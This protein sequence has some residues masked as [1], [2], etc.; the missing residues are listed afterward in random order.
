VTTPS[1][2]SPS[3]LA[4]VWTA[5]VT[6]LKT[7]LTADADR[8]V[9]HMDWLAENGSHG[10]VLFGTTGEANS[11]S[12]SERR[13][14][15]DE[16]AARGADFDRLIV[17]TGNTAY[18]DAAELTQHALQLGARAVL[19]LPPFYYAP[20]SDDGLFAFTSRMLE[21]VS[22]ERKPI[23]LYHYPRM[24]GTGYSIPVIHR[25]ME[26]WPGVIEGIK[27]SSGDTDNLTQYC[28][29][30]EGVSVFAGSEALLPYALEEG[31]VGCI[32]A[33]ANVTSRLA[34]AVYDGDKGAADRMIRTRKAVE[35]LPLI[36]ALKRI[37]SDALDEPVWRALRPPLMPLTPANEARLEEI[38]DTV[39]VLPNFREDEDT[40]MPT[41]SVI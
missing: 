4:G 34:R 6:P 24:A 41:S 10:T 8:L 7:D 40:E 20:V 37:L 33:T 21:Q 1:Q 36:P 39:G 9:H 11:F 25:L 16:L 29:E 32:S 19:L 17:G 31:G 38:L 3:P 18:P 30:L 12:L 22:C 2:D 28:R 26:A 23:V 14:L 35:A 5:S 13:T 15:L 27:D